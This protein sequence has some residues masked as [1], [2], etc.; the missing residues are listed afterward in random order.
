MLSGVLCAFVLAVPAAGESLERYEFAQIH[1]GVPF[2]IRFYAPDQAV[3]TEAS[4]AAFRRI[5]QLNAM[6]SDYDPESELMRLSRTAGSGQAVKVSPELLL[7]LSRSKELWRRSDGAF[8][9]TV[10]PVVRLWRRARR[11]GRLPDAAALAEARRAVG[12]QF[13][14]IDVKGGTVELA[15]PGMRLDLGAIAKGYAADEALRV[16]KEHGVSRA[17]VD[18][19]GDLAV[20]DPPPGRQGWRIAVAPLDRKDRGPRPSLVIANGAVATSGDAYQ[21]VEIGGVR[22][23]HIVDPKTGLGLTTSSSVTV[24][25]PDGMTAD[26]LASAVSVLGPQRGLALIEETKG[27]AALVV[28][29]EDSEP[30][31]FVSE[32]FEEFAAPSEE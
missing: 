5:K 20:G 25:A 26:A 1:M 16:L 2:T 8:D 22:Y 19:S 32:R 6:L 14:K 3:A 21:H 29:V 27:A 7:L 11:D 28:Q 12:S 9:V 15:Q 13:L 10:G 24:I 31:T 23:S 4:R 17:L 18:A 30:V